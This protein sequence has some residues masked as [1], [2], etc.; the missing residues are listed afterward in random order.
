MATNTKTNLFLELAPLPPNFDG[1]PQEFAQALV[2]RLRIVAP[3]G[4]TNF[5]IG[6]SKPTSNQGPWL[7]DGVQWW[8]WSDTEADYVPQD[9]TASA[10]VPY[11]I[12]SVEPPTF[13]PAVWIEVNG[14]HFINIHTAVDNGAGGLRW[15]PFRNKSGTT[16]QRP[17]D[18]FEFERYY[19]ETIET[20]IWF[21]RGAWRTTSGVRGD[22]KYVSWA[23]S[24]EALARN[25]GWEILGTG[26]TNNTAW[27][28][29]A[30]SQATKDTIPGEDLDV[31]SGI[32]EHAPGDTFG[33]ETHTLTT[34]QIPAHT[35]TFDL[36]VTGAPDGANKYADWESSANA[37][38]AQP[39]A[40][41]TQSTGGGEAHNNLGPRLAL[42]CLRK[43]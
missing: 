32:S 22:V 42:W 23:T 30:L 35:H 26:E 31:S 6:G 27:R 4:L 39:A 19:D 25:P 9:L 5:V 41:V 34:A 2:E 14:T 40:G 24:T 3:F 20:E 36:E 10:A 18:P 16:A 43:T 15:E 33:A 8:V 28:G 7:K 21:E 13:T 37:T 17:A 1:T 11:V 38:P 29:R 12:T